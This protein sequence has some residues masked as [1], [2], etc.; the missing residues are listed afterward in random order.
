V[1]QPATLVLRWVEP[2]QPPRPVELD[3]VSRTQRGSPV[4]PN[5]AS[6]AFTRL[7]ATVGLD[8]WVP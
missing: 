2:G 4:N 8:V 7:A 3:L 5:H 6:R 1:R